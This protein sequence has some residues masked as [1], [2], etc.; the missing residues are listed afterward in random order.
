VSASVEP[1]G[2]DGEK[3]YISVMYHSPLFLHSISK[4]LP[5]QYSH[6]P[7]TLHSLTLVKMLFTSFLPTLALISSVLS[8]NIPIQTEA[9]RSI[10][11]PMSDI[12][13]RSLFSRDLVGL[14]TCVIV[15]A[16]VQVTVTT[17]SVSL[18]GVPIIPQDLNVGV[19]PK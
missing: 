15:P 11:Q 5:H 14:T 12:D 4:S 2:K 13:S 3:R 19:N 1:S 8:S 10:S 6:P 17:P 9:T 16:N 18:L 7:S